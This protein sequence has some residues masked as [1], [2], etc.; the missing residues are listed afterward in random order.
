M[1]MKYRKKSTVIIDAY[2]LKISKLLEICCVMNNIVSWH[3]K[4]DGIYFILTTTEGYLLAKEGDYI[5]K[6]IDGKFYSCDQ[7]TFEISYEKIEEQCTN[8]KRKEEPK[9]HFLNDD[10]LDDHEYAFETLYCK[11][12]KEMIHAGNNELMQT[13]VQS[14]KGNYCLTCFSSSIN[15]GEWDE[16][17]L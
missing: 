1:L 7:N 15:V 6:R 9:I 11:N 17:I 14:H 3:K 8:E 16:D 4:E 12:C 10:L 2:Q 5:I 13:W